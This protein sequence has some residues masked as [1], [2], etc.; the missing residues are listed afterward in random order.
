ME[1]REL[2]L[3]PG[4]NKTL[5]FKYEPEELGTYRISLDDRSSTVAVEKFR[6]NYAMLALILLLLMVLGTAFYVYE[7]GKLDSLMKNLRGGK[8]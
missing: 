4:E 2:G 7:T 6:P 5:T 3:N 8:A 1:T